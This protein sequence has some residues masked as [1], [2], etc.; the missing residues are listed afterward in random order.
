MQKRA[1]KIFDTFD[2]IK[3]DVPLE[4]I[5]LTAGQLSLILD[6]PNPSISYMKLKEA[7]DLIKADYC[8]F[9]EDHFVV[10]LYQESYNSE[11]LD[12]KVRFLGKVVGDMADIICACTGNEIYIDNYQIKCYLDVQEIDL[13]QFSQ[14]NDLFEDTGLIIF[15]HRPYIV[16]NRDIPLEENIFIEEIGGD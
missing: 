3:K 6:T 16:F 5:R 1:Q 8:G 11:I 2:A 4:A 13:E 9:Y 10:S 7:G 14:I 15:A 12:E